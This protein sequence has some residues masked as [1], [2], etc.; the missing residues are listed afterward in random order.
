MRT[1][2]T[3]AKDGLA[4]APAIELHGHS[5]RRQSST[6]I[7]NVRRLNHHE[8]GEYNTFYRPS[9]SL[10]SVRQTR[11]ATQNADHLY[12]VQSQDTP[13]A[14][15]HSN[16]SNR[17]GSFSKGSPLSQKQDQIEGDG[18]SAALSISDRSHF[19]W[20]EN[21]TYESA[22]FADYGTPQVP[23]GDGNLF[24]G[25]APMNSLSPLLNT[26]GDS[27]PTSKHCQSSIGTL[28]PSLTRSPEF[29]KTL[30]SKD[31]I[32][33]SSDPFRRIYPPTVVPLDGCRYPVLQPLLPYIRTVIPTT[34]AC[35]LLDLYFTE[36]STSLFECASPY[37][38]T[39]IFRKKSFL[40]N[41]A[42]RQTSPALLA[43]MLWVTAQTSNAQIFKADTRARPRIC[44]QLNRIC[45]RLLTPQDQETPARK[46]CT[47]N[48]FR[49][50]S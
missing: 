1:S 50:P 25:R 29:S 42:P 39:R 15:I 7:S 27:N 41:N 6:T 26:L 37:V 17:N 30:G 34:E 44:D 32:S 24:P 14:L 8:Y 13:P 40:S 18:E 46:P 47:F 16:G 2:N 35:D 11:D 20:P 5:R 43:A 31:P 21:H 3:K 4:A 23:S 36:P 49:L 10:V 33:H 9:S 22:S 19:P 45:I 48:P 28:Q 12:S 38:L